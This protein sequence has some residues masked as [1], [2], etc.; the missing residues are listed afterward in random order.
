MPTVAPPAMVRTIGSWIG[1]DWV[2][3]S[4]PGRLQRRIVREYFSLLPWRG[5]KRG[6]ASCWS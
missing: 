6:C 5:T 1:L 4:L 3:P 2:D